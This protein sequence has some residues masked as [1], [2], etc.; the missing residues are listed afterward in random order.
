[1]KVERVSYDIITP[2]AARGIVDSIIWKPQMRWRIESI[3]VLAP[4]RFQA[5]K[6]N[7][8]QSTIPVTGA[9]GVN[10]W[11][12]DPQKYVPQAAGAGQGTDATPRNTL[13]LRDVAYII[14]ASPIVFDSNDGNNTP[15]KYTEMFTRRLSKGQCYT[16][17]CFGCR[18]FVATVEPPTGDEIPLAE[19]RDLGFMLYDILFDKSGKNNRPLFFRAQM[20]NGVVD[21]RPEIAVHDDALRKELLSCSY[22]H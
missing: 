8:V 10:A 9:S 20:N 19:T 4:I 3:T 6:R 22:T 5:L 13:A 11:M 17:P 14:E 12:K 7:E 1:M 21:T 18:E 15:R 2:S 16:R